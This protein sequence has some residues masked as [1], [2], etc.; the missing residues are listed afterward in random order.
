MKKTFFQAL[1]A[2][3][4]ICSFTQSSFSDINND[5]KNIGKRF[6]ST[7]EIKSMCNATRL[8]HEEF[9]K[10]KA[11]QDSMYLEY[12]KNK[13]LFKLAKTLS[14]PD[15]K[16]YMS[17]VDTQEVGIPCWSFS[18]V[19]V[20]ECLLHYYHGS[21]IGINLSETDIVDAIG[22]QNTSTGGL[23]YI[24][25][26]K[27]CTESNDNFPNYDN[28]YYKIT[29]RSYVNSG[30]DSIKTA[31]NSSPVAVSFNVY[32]DFGPFFDN[33][34]YGVYR[35]DDE[36][37][38]VDPH[39]VVIVDYN[40]E[41]EYW[42]CKNSWG[43]AWGDSGYFKIG[44]GECLIEYR[45]MNKAIVN[46]D[47][48]FAK[49][50]PGLISSLSTSLGY[51][52]ATNEWAYIN[53]NY[54]FPSSSS[55]T[56]NGSIMVTSGST[57]TVGSNSTIE[58]AT[59]KKI[60][61]EGTLVL[62]SGSTLEHVT[63]NDHWGY[64]DINSGGTLSVTG[65]ATIDHS[66]GVLIYGDVSFPSNDTSTISNGNYG[67]LWFASGSETIRNII[68]DDNGGQGIYSQGS[69]T[70]G[71]ANNVT[72]TN[73]D[74]GAKLGSGGNLTLN[75]SLIED[76]DEDCIYIYTSASALDID[77]NDNDFYPDS[78]ATDYVISNVSGDYFYAEDNYWGSAY[79]DEDDLFRY[80]AYVYW[81]PHDTFPN[82]AGAPKIAVG[83]I[84]KKSSQGS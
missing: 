14:I 35:Y 30:I 43:V 16:Y 82:G 56:S 80:P 12:K 1:I 66:D 57:F 7:E 68:F 70:L 32:E 8:P 15:W 31:L 55:T 2:C 4:I 78:G 42:I 33:S 18:S 54:S 25:D 75:D 3:L 72:I 83:Q 46:N 41:E 44:F 40:D 51:S 34:P 36:S 10:L 63:G 52:W 20:A 64:L 60:D 27:V 22:T 61:V 67:G 37:D 39:A 84:A 17:P 69:S 81:E 77:M 59:D 71:T 47:S 23:N 5:T 62:N 9:V 19:A 6:Y 28:S 45:I 13:K 74:Y 48:C 58:M 38:I 26:Y 65:E 11:L 21:D 76:I 73:S 24:R 49:I 29:D 53:S 79:P 50:T